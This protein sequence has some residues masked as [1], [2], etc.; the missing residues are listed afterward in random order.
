VQYDPDKP[1][2]QQGR[3]IAAG[4]MLFSDDEHCALHSLI[5]V[6]PKYKIQ[7]DIPLTEIEK[8]NVDLDAGTNTVMLLALIA[9]RLDLLL[10]H[11]ERL[12]S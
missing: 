7:D 1:P 6:L 8:Q 2:E 12:S 9:V 4:E 11:Y 3:R 5:T 10:K